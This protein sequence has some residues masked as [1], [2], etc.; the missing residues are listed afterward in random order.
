M[1][2]AVL[3][4]AGKT[5]RVLIE[6]CLRRGHEVIALARS[7]ENID[8]T[9]P[10]VQRR[11][12]DAFERDS[13]LAGLAGADAVI[14]SVGKTD[15][16]DKRVNLSTA[17][18]RHVLDGMR[19]H[20]I[21][22]LVVISSLGALLGVRRPG[23]RRNLYLY[24]RRR[25]YGDMHEMEK[26]VLAEPGIRAS[27]VRAPMLDNGPAEARF[28]LQPDERALPRG[29]RVSRSDLAR[30][31]LDE[32]EKPQHTGRIVALANPPD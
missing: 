23:I 2:I 27:V 3:G 31:L 24:F 13:V 30:F 19:A 28:E 29:S 22:R 18:H 10:R 7:P 16:R 6:E 9:D 21:S 8:N 5:G 15:L 32:I 25:Y 17:G 26:M 4:A 20:G 11:R 12:A 1:K 14:T